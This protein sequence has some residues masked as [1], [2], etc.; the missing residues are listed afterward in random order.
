[1]KPL[2]I[3]L[4]QQIALETR[5]AYVVRPAPWSP[6]VGGVSAQSMVPGT[7]LP[8][9]TLRS[10]EARPVPPQGQ[11]GG[12]MES[13][14]TSE[15]TSLHNPGKAGPQTEQPGPPANSSGRN[16]VLDRNGN[17]AGGPVSVTPQT[18]TE[19]PGQGGPGTWNRRCASF[20]QGAHRRGEK[21]EPDTQTEPAPTQRSTLAVGP[22]STCVL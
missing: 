19:Y 8:G 1:M 5:F 18:P 17:G 4:I 14:Q 9:L 11:A 12:P 15:A 16:L 7:G 3:L 6:C 20:S 13:G 21:G 22:Y 2:L 10:W